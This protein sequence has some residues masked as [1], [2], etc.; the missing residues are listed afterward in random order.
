MA[1]SQGDWHGRLVLQLP[2][3]KSSYRKQLL[4]VFTVL[5]GI[6]W[7]SHI[8]CLGQKLVLYWGCWRAWYLLQP[9]LSL[10]DSSGQKVIVYWGCGRTAS[11]F[12]L[13]RPIPSLFDSFDQKLSSNWGCGENKATTPLHPAHRPLFSS[14]CVLCLFRP[15]ATSRLSVQ[16]TSWLWWTFR[17]WRTCT[18]TPRSTPLRA[19]SMVMAIWGP[20]E[21]HSFSTPTSAT[22]FAKACSS[23]PLTW[24]LRSSPCCEISSSSRSVSVMRSCVSALVTFLVLLLSLSSLCGELLHAV[25]ASFCFKKNKKKMGWGRGGQL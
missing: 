1:V 25:S 7:F 16:A 17:A 5:L 24:R 12:W 3:G 11:P 20:R 4:N 21:W 2:N 10:F 9:T 13:L 15:S 19:R 8:L 18:L 14:C 23:L 22:K 6:H